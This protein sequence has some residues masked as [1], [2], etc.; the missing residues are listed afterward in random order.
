MTEVAR[1]YLEG[2]PGYDRADVLDIARLQAAAEAQA[3]YSEA[4]LI[5]CDTDLTV[6]QVW[7]EEKYG[8]LPQE[9]N[10][11]LAE[12]SERAYLL[13]QPDLPWA[14][15]PLRENPDDRARLFERY[16]RLLAASPFPYRVVSGTDDARWTSALAAVRALYPELVPD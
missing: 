13:M 15:D 8:A 14:A 6:I 9:L 5:V 4:E 16:Q 11:A 7:W 10:V 1:E 12:R 2:R 3:L